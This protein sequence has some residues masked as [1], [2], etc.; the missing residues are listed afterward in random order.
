[1][2]ARGCWLLAREEHRTQPKVAQLYMPLRIQQQVVRLNV[3]MDEPQLMDRVDCED[4]FCN[5]MS[6]HIT[7]EDVVFHQRLQ[8]V[9]V[10]VCVCVCGVS[11]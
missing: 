2:V 3:S 9:C 8:C 11:I 6:T 5:V 7:R 4:G 1:M 10:C